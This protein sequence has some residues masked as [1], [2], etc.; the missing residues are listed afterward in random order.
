MILAC[1]HALAFDC[2]PLVP[3]LY[4]EVVRPPTSGLFGVEGDIIAFVDI[5]SCHQEFE[6][7]AVRLS[8]FFEDQPM[9]AIPVSPTRSR[10]SRF[11]PKAARIGTTLQP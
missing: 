5:L 1:L 9:K 7:T 8:S 10:L 2:E 6:Q 4:I 11:L 3:A